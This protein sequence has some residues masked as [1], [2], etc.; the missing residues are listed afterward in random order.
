MSR[1]RT[2]RLRDRA[3][4]PPQLRVH[5]IGGGKVQIEYDSKRRLCGVA[6]G[7]CRGVATFYGEHITIDQPECMER[8]APACRLMVQVL[9]AQAAV[10]APR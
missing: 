8:G 1:H 7:I 4:V 6:V 2:V 5:P 10:G 9:G 3:A